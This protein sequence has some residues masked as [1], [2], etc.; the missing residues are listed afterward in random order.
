LFARSRWPIAAALL[1]LSTVTISSAAS[2]HLTVKPK[3]VRAG[4]HFRVTVTGYS[5]HSV[6]PVFMAC[7]SQHNPI[8]GSWIWKG[9]A[10]AN[11]TLSLQILAPT[12]TGAVKRASTSCRVYVTDSSGQFRLSVPLK[13]L[14]PKK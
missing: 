9:K 6:Q 7:T 1:A 14:S 11:G 8:Y 4:T 2:Q 5:A 13:I 3:S 10:D 12:P